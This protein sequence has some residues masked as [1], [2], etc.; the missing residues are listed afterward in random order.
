VVQVVGAGG[1]D[2][3]RGLESLLGVGSIENLVRIALRRLT[4][5]KNASGGRTEGGRAKHTEKTLCHFLAPQD[6]G[7][8]RYSRSVCYRLV[9]IIRI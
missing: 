3:I 6:S 4:T 7:V 8:R 2:S 1:S 5:F 9:R